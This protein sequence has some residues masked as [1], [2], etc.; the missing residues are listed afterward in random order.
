[1]FRSSSFVRCGPVELRP[2]ILQFF[3]NI[4]VPWGS[5]EDHVFQKVGHA[6]LAISFMD[7]ANQDG[8]LTVMVAFNGSGKRRTRSPFSSLYSLM[9]STD[10][11]RSIPSG[12]GTWARAAGKVRTR[13]TNTATKDLADFMET[14]ESQLLRW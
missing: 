10:V 3:R 5:L 12:N 1:M 4:L 13:K 14:S 8:H 6:G 9:P 2:V 7:E 11:S